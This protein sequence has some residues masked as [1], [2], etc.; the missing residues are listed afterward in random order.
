VSLS[1]VGGVVCYL[2]WSHKLLY[3]SALDFLSVLIKGDV[4]IVG[5]VKIV[6]VWLKTPVS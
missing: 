5:V 1:R 3:R 6:Y 2:E 4:Q